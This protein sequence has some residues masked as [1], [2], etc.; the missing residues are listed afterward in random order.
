MRPLPLLLV[1]R[2]GVVVIP[3]RLGREKPRNHN[4]SRWTRCSWTLLPWRTISHR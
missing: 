1:L 3:P 2:Q 4:S